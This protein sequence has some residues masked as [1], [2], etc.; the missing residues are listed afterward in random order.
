MFDYRLYARDEAFDLLTEPLP[1]NL[2]DFF[3][4]QLQRARAILRHRN[5]SEIDY[6]IDSLDWFLQEG[7]RH[8]W[9]DIK[10]I[11]ESQ[12]EAFINRTKALKAYMPHIDIAEQSQLPH[13][14]WAEYFATLSLAI[15]GET[16]Y[17][18]ADSPAE[19]GE[20]TSKDHL[21]KQIE[22]ELKNNQKRIECENAIEC[23]ES[24]CHAEFQAA[25]AESSS[26]RKAAG[27]KGGK[28]KAKRF[29]A[30]K[31]HV[32]ELYFVRFADLSNRKAADRIYGE[33]SREE[34]KL[35][36]SIEPEITIAK[37]IASIKKQ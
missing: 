9:E 33:L 29:D 3:G 28:I 24:V 2:Q 4:D 1:G 5:K 34:Q 31:L 20:N 12:E 13:A 16:L 23:M 8:L 35:F 21:Q 10:Q 32:R 25:L 6:A 22:R 7:S 18:N 36:E 27:R 14:T 15:I 17:S 19:S 30:V 11:L 26:I 37:W